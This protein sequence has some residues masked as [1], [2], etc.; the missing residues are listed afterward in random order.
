M[1][2]REIP[3]SYIRKKRVD[4]EE[5]KHQTEELWLL[6]KVGLIIYMSHLSTKTPDNAHYGILI[7]LEFGSV[8]NWFIKLLLD[9]LGCFFSLFSF[10]F[11]A[12]FI[13]SSLL[14]FHDIGITLGARGG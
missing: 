13:C 8:I 2:G 9:N 6:Y 1:R 3:L 14:L 4:A 11:S 10:F 12:L 5:L 7:C